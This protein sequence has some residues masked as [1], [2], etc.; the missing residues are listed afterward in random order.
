[1]CVCVC[2]FLRV[3]SATSTSDPF[4]MV[5]VESEDFIITLVYKDFTSVFAQKISSIL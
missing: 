2:C 4:L 5:T 3:K 1:M